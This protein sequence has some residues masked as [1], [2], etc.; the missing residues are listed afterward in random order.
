MATWL[1]FYWYAFSDYPQYTG[2]YS[3]E[4]K[5]Y[6]FSST[7]VI[8]DDPVFLRLW[9]DLVQNLVIGHK[10][11]W[12]I[13]SEWERQHLNDNPIKIWRWMDC[14]FMEKSKNCFEG[15]DV[16]LYST[17]DDKEKREA[18]QRDNDNGVSATIQYSGWNESY[19]K[20]N[21]DT[22][23]APTPLEQRKGA[24]VLKFEPN[25]NTEVSGGNC[26]I[27]AFSLENQSKKQVKSEV[28]AFFSDIL[29]QCASFDRVDANSNTWQIDT[30]RFED[31]ETQYATSILSGNLN[32][33]KSAVSKD[34]FLKSGT[35]SPLCYTIVPWNSEAYNLAN[36]SIHI[37]HEQFKTNKR[38]ACDM[39]GKWQWLEGLPLHISENNSIPI[40]IQGYPLRGSD[41]GYAKLAY[42]AFKRVPSEVHDV[43]VSESQDKWI[44]QQMID[45]GQK[46]TWEVKIEREA[47]RIDI[48]AYEQEKGGK[49][50]YI[51]KR[52]DV[53]P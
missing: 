4:Y 24:L 28:C 9:P 49:S 36:V 32:Y 30:L 44:E 5:R 1:P 2:A 48:W 7:P 15:I 6:I 51:F 10:R 40:S 27:V 53:K 37:G 12:L 23:I 29:L 34:V 46:L 47:S 3:E 14:R 13:F 16:I 19:F 25:E 41:A 8:T 45:P 22:G 52:F 11:V 17:Q 18:V 26:R 35:Y 42:L 33:G 50:H 20:S 31:W 38:N 43:S 21:P 39:T